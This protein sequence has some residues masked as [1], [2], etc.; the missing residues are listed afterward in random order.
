M[1]S[2]IVMYYLEENPTI[3]RRTELNSHGLVGQGNTYM[4]RE[5]EVYY[6]ACVCA[7]YLSFCQPKR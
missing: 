2:R 5:A 4:D 3:S 6:H 7:S 1:F